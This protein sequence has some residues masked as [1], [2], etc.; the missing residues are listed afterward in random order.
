LAKKNPL[1]IRIFSCR[2]D[3]TERRGTMAEFLI[4]TGDE[5]VTL[6]G[7]AVRGLL[8]R[9]DGDAAL[10]YIAL[11]RH[12]GTVMPRS[13]ASELRWERPRIEA[14]EHTLQELK[15]IRPRKKKPLP[16]RRRNAVLYAA[17]RGGAAGGERRVPQR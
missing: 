1:S 16:R 4:H 7:P 9:G 5:S 2:I 3:E 13:L 6:S 11:L 15:L 14:A 10:L 12:N 17:G 8:G